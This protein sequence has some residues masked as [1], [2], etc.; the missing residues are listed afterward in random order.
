M[1]MILNL[2]FELH[3]S[4]ISESLSLACDLLIV[5]CSFIFPILF[6]FIFCDSLLYSPY[7]G[8][9]V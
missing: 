6:I 7:L 1:G 5:A 8:L 2:L 4:R 3:F 9:N